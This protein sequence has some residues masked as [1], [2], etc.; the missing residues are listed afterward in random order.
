MQD[1][2]ADWEN[3]Y[4]I[5]S[6]QQALRSAADLLSNIQVP[7]TEYPHQ[8]LGFKVQYKYSNRPHFICT[9]ALFSPRIMYLLVTLP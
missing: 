1:S 7:G 3:T 8:K 2:S 5:S 9:V 6:E 4:H